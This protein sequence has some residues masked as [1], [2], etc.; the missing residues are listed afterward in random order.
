MGHAGLGGVQNVVGS[1]VGPSKWG[2]YVNE[3]ASKEWD[4]E[5]AKGAASWAMKKFFSTA[6]SANPD[7]DGADDV[8]L[9]NDAAHH[10]TD[11]LVKSIG[12]N[13]FGKFGTLRRGR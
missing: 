12:T 3:L 4:T 10:E 11:S 7:W 6:K 8:S 9:L 5:F 13:F 2:K 1:V